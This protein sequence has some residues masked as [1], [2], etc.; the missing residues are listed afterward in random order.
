M[1]TE[2]YK[3]CIDAC[4]LC[5]TACRHCAEECLKE[6]DVEK[7]ARCIKLDNDC[8]TLCLVAAIAMAG[9]SDFVKQIC[10]LCAQ[11]CDACGEECGKHAHMEHCKQSAQACR[12]CAEAC[13]KMAA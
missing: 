3:S 10:A 5:A 6:Q 7:L 8:S 9:E 4:Y 12:N 1:N 13:R 11:V 2:I